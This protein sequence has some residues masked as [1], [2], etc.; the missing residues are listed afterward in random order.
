LNLGA[1]Y[2]CPSLSS[3]HLK[4]VLKGSRHEFTVSSG[5]HGV[6]GR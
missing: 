3:L 2:K 4:S 5:A 1:T 6:A